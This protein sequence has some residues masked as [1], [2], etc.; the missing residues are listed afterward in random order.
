[1]KVVKL[2]DELA[3]ATKNLEEAYGKVSRS[4]YKALEDKVKKLEQDTLNAEADFDCTF[5]EDYN[6]GLNPNGLSFSVGY[7]GRCTQCQ[8][9]VKFQHD[10]KVEF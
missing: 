9:E 4:D 2:R 5:R 7:L 6:I 8:F 3:T 1:M 10:Q